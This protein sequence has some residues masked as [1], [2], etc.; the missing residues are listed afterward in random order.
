MIWQAVERERMK[1]MKDVLLM[2]LFATV[3]SS[4]VVLHY[5]CEEEPTGPD[6]DCGSGPFSYDSKTGVCRDM[7][8][9]SIVNPDCCAR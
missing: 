7:S 6:L 9:N 2:L 4:V 1:R 5:G 3:L 8:T